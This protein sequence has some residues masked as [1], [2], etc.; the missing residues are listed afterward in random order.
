[1]AYRQ[2]PLCACVSV[3]MDRNGA[4]IHKHAKKEPVQYPAFLI[5]R[6]VDEGFII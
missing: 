1:M 4:R 6:L 5:S 3:C 2:N